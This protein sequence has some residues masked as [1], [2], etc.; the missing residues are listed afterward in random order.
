[1]WIITII[2]WVF[3]AIFLALFGGLWAGYLAG[4]K[5]QTNKNDVEDMIDSS[6]RR[7]KD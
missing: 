4:A 2:A 1:M 5:H 6:R 3:K 7:S